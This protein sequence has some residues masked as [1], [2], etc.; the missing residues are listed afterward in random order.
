[1]TTTYKRII[2]STNPTN[3]VTT[4]VLNRPKQKNAMDATMCSEIT[5]A[6]QEL[7]INNKNT[8]NITKALIITGSGDY[9]SSGNDLSNFAQ[10]SHPRTM[11]KAVR[12]NCQALVD[13]FIYTKV[14]I[15]VAVNGPAIGIMVTTMGLCDYRLSLPTS[16]LL[17]PFKA[18]GQSPEGCSSYTFSRIMGQKW[19]DDMLVH[20]K[21][22]SAKEGKEAGLIDEIVG[23][24]NNNNNINLKLSADEIARNNKLLLD[25]AEVV[26]LEKKRMTENKPELLKILHDVNVNECDILQRKMLSPECFE[27]LSTYLTSRGKTLPAAVIRA[28]NYTRFVWDR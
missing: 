11:A 21:K 7:S 24:N 13:S 14:P 6:L 16:T 12:D 2:L 19:A 22:L 28:M 25:R 15:I 8:T 27:A 9:Y 3:K 10:L 4:L 26:A 23:D 18:L 20:G 1:M 17:T 5:S